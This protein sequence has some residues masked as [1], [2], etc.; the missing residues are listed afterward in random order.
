MYIDWT[1]LLLLNLKGKF[2]R[3][4]RGYMTK[5][6]AYEELK[7]LTEQDFGYDT[8]KW[9]AFLSRKENSCIK[10]IDRR[11]KRKERARLKQRTTTISRSAVPNVD[12][13][14]SSRH[15][16]EDAVLRPDA[17]RKTRRP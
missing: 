12:R 17:M 7:D 4:V 10:L 9:E 15:T 8:D 3:T 11:L 16:A 13:P 2:R 5:A 1:K 14:S 6:Q